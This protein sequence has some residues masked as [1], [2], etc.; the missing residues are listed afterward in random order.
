MGISF[1][2][3]DNL[4]DDKVIE[5]KMKAYGRTISEL[6]DLKAQLKKQRGG[7]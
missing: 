6:L 2:R 1:H 7:K 5:E 3:K 4:P